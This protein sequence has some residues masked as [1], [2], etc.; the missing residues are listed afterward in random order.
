M[1]EGMGTK[2]NKVGN[3]YVKAILG[4]LLPFQETDGKIHTTLTHVWNWSKN[5]VSQ[6]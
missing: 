6:V 2:E 1:N 3:H 5:V 4:N